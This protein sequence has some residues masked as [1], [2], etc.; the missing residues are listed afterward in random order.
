M[1]TRKRTVHVFAVNPTGSV[2]GEMSHIGGR[3]YDSSSQSALSVEGHPITR[4]R[5]DGTPSQ[6]ACNPALVLT[7]IRVGL[8][9][10][11]NHRAYPS[12]RPQRGE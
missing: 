8:V 2:P 7:L 11:Q 12:E 3:V 6:D 9:V 5:A 4:S 1:G 10:Y